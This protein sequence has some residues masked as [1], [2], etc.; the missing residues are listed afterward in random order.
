VAGLE[1]QKA[2][3]RFP[4]AL[5]PQEQVIPAQKGPGRC[6]PVQGKGWSPGGGSSPA[7]SL[8]WAHRVGRGSCG[9][10][11]ALLTE[12]WNRLLREVVESPSLEIFKP[13]LNKVL[14]SLL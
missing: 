9:A 3:L 8:R 11:G 1:E 12:H 6:L 7:P 5:Q 10:F 4:T 13:C 14:C 2:V